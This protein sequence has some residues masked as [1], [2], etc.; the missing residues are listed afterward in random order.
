M[1]RDDLCHLEVNGQSFCETTYALSFQQEVSARK[2]SI[3]KIA[4]SGCLHGEQM[5]GDFGDWWTEYEPL[6][7]KCQTCGGKRW[8]RREHTRG[9]FAEAGAV[10]VQEYAV[11]R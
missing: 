4:R 2:R 7:W 10:G 5:H 3:D 8:W 9:S 6:R 11:T 1:V